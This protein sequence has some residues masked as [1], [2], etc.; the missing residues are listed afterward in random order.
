MW[1][2]KRKV[3]GVGGDCVQEDGDVW[4][5]VLAIFR[6]MDWNPYLAEWKQS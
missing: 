3:E 6:E 5:V 2:L 1:W 4:V